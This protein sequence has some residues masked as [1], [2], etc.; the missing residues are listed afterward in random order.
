MR[1]DFELG[2]AVFHI[3]RAASGSHSRWY[4]TETPSSFLMH[5]RLFGIFISFFFFF[6]FDLLLEFG[7]T[8]YDRQTPSTS[9]FRT[10]L[11]WWSASWTQSPTGHLYS[12]RRNWLTMLLILIFIV[13]PD[14]EPFPYSVAV[15]F[16]Y[17]SLS[18][19]DCFVVLD[20]PDCPFTRIF[21]FP[22]L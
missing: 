19:L 13:E 10:G 21:G 14:H 1:A 16:L 8:R 2:V 18:L 20:E 3:L 7:W 9:L 12:A 11:K 15:F 22:C 5:A 4:Y 6:F 17:V